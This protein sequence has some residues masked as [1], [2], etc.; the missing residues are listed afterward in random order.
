[1]YISFLFFTL[2]SKTVILFS[3]LAIIFFTAHIPPRSPAGMGSNGLWILEKN[4]QNLL[5]ILFFSYLISSILI[6][7]SVLTIIRP[8]MKE[9]MSQM[10]CKHLK[11]KKVCY[12]WRGMGWGE[13]ICKRLPRRF[14]FWSNLGQQKPQRGL[15]LIINVLCSSPFLVFQNDCLL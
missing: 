15:L 11:G 1:L 13:R 14:F 4:Y 12:L 9:I 3:V 7:F 10:R 8:E 5:D 2:I 6:T